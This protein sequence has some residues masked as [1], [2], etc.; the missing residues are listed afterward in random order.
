MVFGQELSG[1]NALSEIAQK[2]GLG[3]LAERD[4]LQAMDAAGVAS[5]CRFLLIID[6]LND[7]EDARNWKNELLALQGRM[8]GFRHIAL[9][10][11]CRST[12]TDLVVPDRFDG[13]ASDHAGFTGREME[14]LESYLK[15]TLRLFPA[16]LCFPRSSPTLCS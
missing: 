15:E 8:A 14:G 12:F 7:A 1:Q 16:P 13:P 3:A 11:S 4:F 5:G 6:A 10:V 2:R 9:V